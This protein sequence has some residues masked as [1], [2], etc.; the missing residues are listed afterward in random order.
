[1]LRWLLGIEANDGASDGNVRLEWL[2]APSGDAALLLTCAA[3]T[4]CVVVWLLYRWEASR[5]DRFGRLC[6]AGLRLTALAAVAAMLC[7]PVAVFTERT[8][9]PSH[10]LV[11]LDQSQ[12]MKLPDAWPDEAVANRVKKAIDLSSDRPLAEQ[13]RLDLAKHILQ[14]D[15]LSRL[16]QGGNRQVHVH[17]FAEQMDPRTLPIQQSP[18]GVSMGDSSPLLKGHHTAIGTAI[19]QSLMAY[20]GLPLAGI[21]LISDGQSNS[22]ESTDAAAALAADRRLPIHVLAM[23]TER[24]PRNASIVKLDTN[25]ISFVSDTNHVG[26][27]IQSRGMADSEATI[28]LERKRDAGDWQEAGRR[29]V[30]LADDGS[31][32]KVDFQFSDDNPG[33]IELR[34]RLES[35]GGELSLEDNVEMSEVR[36][37]PQ[38]LRVLFIAGSTFPE[39]QFIR[40]TLIRDRGIDLSTWN[41]AAEDDYDHPG[42][43]PIRRLPINDD[44]LDQYD[45]IILYDPDPTQ[46]PPNFHEMIDR[47]VSFSGGGLIYIAGEMQSERSFQNQSSAEMSWL[48]LLPVVRESGLFRSE[49]RMQ[50]SARNAWRLLITPEGLQ[51]PL[52]AFST[53]SA[54][55]QRI[56]ESMPGMYW[57]FPVTR[58]KAG[59]TVLAVH[60]DPRMRNEFGPEVLLATHRV[61][62]GL[63]FFVGFDSTYRWRYINEQTFDG[64]WAR[65]I[66]RAGRAKQLGGGYPFR[67][68][69]DKLTYEPADQV[70]LTAS[71]ADSAFND[72][73]GTSIS[74]E[75]EHG[76]SPAT[77]LSLQPGRQEG[78]FEAS[79]SVAEV[80]HY[81]I[82]AWAGQRDAASN[83][84]T[85]T[86]QIKVE[87]PSSEYEKPV[88]DRGRLESIAAAAGGRVFDLTQIH[89][90]ANAFTIGKVDKVL[91]DRSE[92]W[93]GP[94][95]LVVIVGAIVAE[96]LLRKR[97]QLV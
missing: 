80:G 89:Q 34:A 52:M 38:K 73:D 43:T 37:I 5:I 72:L 21:M 82:R 45:C 28:I 81:L 94:L 49:V 41:Q 77:Q 59:A 4:A 11:L 91:E 48:S 12:S 27:L 85:I 20:R 88:L 58:A 35:A 33:Q 42:D 32:Q 16:G 31:I 95:M 79:F 24:G 90:I 76:S 13:S 39:V 40:N 64:F 60:G 70:H 71:I 75:V 55:N 74:V 29:I 19:Q 15:L 8:R 3:I 26:V 6:L 61:G 1:M 84:K 10:L 67:L 51:D 68:R 18:A 36:L 30:Q 7:E 87:L 62:P 50:L 93:D 23:G 25:P 63:V 66:D 17:G 14:H 96:W 9:I 78:E 53:D 47:F 83:V 97:F 46:W 86:Q 92:I 69:T 22:G 57:H 65:M 44:E 2:S 54:E 56:V